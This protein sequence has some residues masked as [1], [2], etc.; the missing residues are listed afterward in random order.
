MYGFSSHTNPLNVFSNDIDANT[1]NLDSKI[2]ELRDPLTTL[3][4]M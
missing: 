2:E 3:M 4:P 1:M